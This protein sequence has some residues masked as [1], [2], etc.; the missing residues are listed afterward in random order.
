[1]GFTPQAVDKMTL[2]ELSACAAGFARAN[3][4]EQKT[5]APSY[6]EHLETVRRLSALA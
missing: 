5:E 4:A 3:G 2:W 6:E 1:M